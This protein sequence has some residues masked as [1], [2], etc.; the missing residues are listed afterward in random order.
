VDAII[1]VRGEAPL[2]FILMRTI[3]DEAEMLKALQS[4]RDG[5]PDTR[6]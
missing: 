2:G 1:A 4:D 3:A 5:A 6:F